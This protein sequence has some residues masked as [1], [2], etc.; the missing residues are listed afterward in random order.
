MCLSIYPAC[1]LQVVKIKKK[2]KKNLQ[3][4]SI[5][6]AKKLSYDTSYVL[7]IGKGCG[8]VVL[9]STG[10]TNVNRTHSQAEEFLTQ[11]VEPKT[12]ES[13]VVM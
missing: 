4:A 5:L 2:K 13:P 1:E 11:A 9:S 12:R 8:F 6:V 3:Q 7:Q 10:Q